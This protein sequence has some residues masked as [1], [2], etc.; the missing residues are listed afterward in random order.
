[1]RFVGDRFETGKMMK[2][3]LILLFLLGTSCLAALTVA[4]GKTSDYQIVIPDAGNAEDYLNEHI[5]LGG[6]VI[7]TAIRKA[8]GA[9]LP[10]VR[11]SAKLPGKPAIYVGNTKAAAEA[12]L[13][14]GNFKLWEHAIVVRN[15]DIF[16]FG[17]DAENWRK[18]RKSKY[19][20]NYVLGSLKAACTFVEKFANTRFVFQKKQAYG[21]HD[22]IRTL[23][24]KKITVPENFSY[25]KEGRFRQ[26]WDMGGL[27]FSI[28]NN[29]YFGYGEAYDVH[30]HEQS[31]PH[32][33]YYRSN[34]E[35]FALI[36]GKRHYNPRQPQYCLSNPKVQEL[37]YKNALARAD[38]GYKVVEFGQSDGF[39]GCECVPCKKMYDTAD[40]GE[41]IW[42][43]HNDM[44]A[45][46]EK[47][48]PGVI[49]AIA[50]YGPTHKV[51]ASFKKF[52]AGNMIIDLAPT[53]KKLLEQWKKFNVSG[54]AAWTY[55][56][57]SYHPSSFAPAADFDYLRREVRWLRT[58]PVA[59]LFNCGITHTT[60]LGGPWLYAY[61]KW[62]DDPELEPR[63]L[64][65]EYCLFIFGS[66]A[67]P[68]MEKFFMLFDERSKKFPN[69]RNDDFNDFGRKR[70]KS[71]VLWFRRYTP[72]VLAEL[73]KHFSAAEKL[74][75]P[76]E[77]TE[78]LKLEFTY[79]ILTAE[80]NN[81]GN[82][83]LENNSFA[84]RK[85]MAD[86][87]EKRDAFLN[88]LPRRGKHVLGIF[89]DPVMS[90]LRA[91]G[92][93]GGAFGGAFTSDPKNLRQE[94]KD[95]QL[96]RV[97][98]F[99]DPAWKNISA[100]KLIPLK[101]EYKSVNASFKAAFTDK[102][103]LLVCTVPL[104][105]TPDPA[106]P[107]DKTILWRDAVW[108]LFIGSGFARYQMV[109]SAAENSAFDAMRNSANARFDRWNGKW[110]HKDTVKNG[111]WRSE[112]TIP[113]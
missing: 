27:L 8:S 43:L 20:R 98:D 12:G 89:N 34:P 68:H 99:N 11:E 67:A 50:C 92:T 40:W 22:G 62:C 78:K 29:F 76:S 110:S 93:M 94:T 49:P 84:R 57:G 106:P 70:M 33:K 95:I 32:A 19:Y 37:I 80:V 112:V 104:T 91:G 6:K 38:A 105:K 36:N 74:W 30:Y 4:D 35:Y 75:I 3:F 25:R 39:K 64:L 88:S 96:T 113:F 26:N 9:V 59:Y 28:A 23:P 90:V 5:A 54:F 101:P 21:E 15:R 13:S 47:D 63:K 79:F 56:F 102:A 85:I 107:R 81:A 83:L 87:I 53:K 31:I 97:K 69:T 73:K 58:T 103:L 18:V 111:I 14:S 45:K 17:R 86:L 108:E 109:F 42:C 41:K 10:L 48:R 65:Q 52:A 1:M 60:A 46:L 7:Q 61:G 77:F 66:K 2:N 82:A 16:C 24:Q 51:P 71:D 100:Q 44:A 72:Q 55:Y